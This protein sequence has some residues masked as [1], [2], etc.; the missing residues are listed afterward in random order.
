[1]TA[2]SG[3]KDYVRTALCALYK[4]SGIAPLQEALA[5]RAGRRFM[6]VLLFH[7]VTDEVPEDGLTIGV[8]R[9]RRL[10]A[11]L[12]D[13]FRVVPLGEV[14]RLLRERLSFPPR[15]V[16][17]TFDDCY[18]DN[19][20]AAHVLAEHRL[21]ASFFV[22]TGFV[23][24]DH[25]FPW[26]RHLPRRLANLTWDEVREMAAMGFEI[27]SHTVTHLDL[28]VAPVEQARRELVASKAVLEERLGRPVHWLAYPFGGPHNFRRELLQVLEEAGYWGCLSG[29]SGFVVPETD[30]RLL[31]REAVPY[32]KSWLNLK[33]HLTGCLNWLYAVKRRLGLQPPAAGDAELRTAGPAAEGPA[34]RGAAPPIGVSHP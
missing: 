24:T 27:G 14:H 22:P 19:L 32:F 15:T 3:L 2:M 18:R 33:L 1:M 16:A 30:P 21:P 8:A 13:R 6:A 17:I 23:G 7:R 26:D 25:V 4:Y 10:C 9:F 34:P 20:G 11:L 12:R 29:I 28:G 31:P 5:R